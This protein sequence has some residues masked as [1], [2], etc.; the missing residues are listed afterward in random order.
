MLGRGMLCY[1]DL[2]LA[3]RGGEVCTKE[4]FCSQ[5]PAALLKSIDSLI[6]TY[7]QLLLEASDFTT[8]KNSPN[9]PKAKAQIC[10]N[11]LVKKKI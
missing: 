11:F 4:R 7:V 8:P 6:P 2:A 1:R 3:V 5:G 10:F 9:H